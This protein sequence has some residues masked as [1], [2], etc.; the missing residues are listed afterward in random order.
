[1]CCLFLLTIALPD[2]KVMP[3]ILWEEPGKDITMEC[4]VMGEPFPIVQWLKNDDPLPVLEDD[5]NKYTII[6]DGTKLTI[7]DI[8]FSD[9]GAYMCKGENSAGKRLDIASL[10]VIDKQT[11]STGMLLHLLRL[12]L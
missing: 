4:R 2:V 10:V 1:M 11:P 7:R 5:P 12:S 9:T 3:H 6:G 8:Y